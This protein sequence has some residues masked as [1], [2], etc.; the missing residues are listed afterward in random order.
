MPTTPS[1]WQLLILALFLWFSTMRSMSPPFSFQSCSWWI[2]VFVLIQSH[3]IA[4]N[5]VLYIS[6]IATSIFNKKMD[7]IHLNNSTKETHVTLEERL[8]SPILF[9]DIRQQDS[10]S[11]ESYAE[12]FRIPLV[13]YFSI[14][15]NDLGLDNMYID[16]HGRSEYTSCLAARNITEAE[17]KCESSVMLIENKYIEERKERSWIEL[18]VVSTTRVSLHWSISQCIRLHH[19]QTLLR[20]YPL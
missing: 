5:T 1:S 19:Q 3:E 12:P 18:R 13:F 15:E 8:L 20:L 7:V 14:G 16:S 2:Q 11:E 6:G 10:Y 9:V 4:N 17:W